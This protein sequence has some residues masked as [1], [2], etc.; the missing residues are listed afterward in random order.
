MFKVGDL[1]IVEEWPGGDTFPVGIVTDVRSKSP[2]PISVTFGT[3]DIDDIDSIRV[4]LD[5]RLQTEEHRT[6]GF[7]RTKVR[8][9]TKLDRILRGLV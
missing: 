8:K 3:L 7:E 1:V 6:P 9:V 2:Y 4:T 5:G